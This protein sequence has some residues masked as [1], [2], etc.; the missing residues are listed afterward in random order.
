MMIR[1]IRVEDACS[2][3]SD[4]RANA[5]NVPRIPE[6]HEGSKQ[7]GG[8]AGSRRRSRPVS[9][10]RPSMLCCVPRR[11]RSASLS[12]GVLIRSVCLTA[13]AQYT[14]ACTP[15]PATPRA[16]CLLATGAL[17]S[18]VGRP[19][20]GR[21]WLGRCCPLVA[22][23]GRCWVGVDAGIPETSW[24]PALPL[25]PQHRVTLE[26]PSPSLGLSSPPEAGEVGAWGG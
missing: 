26:G 1:V 19:Q 10:G 4:Q 23:A 12:L 8:K 16:P 2:T 22:A 20:R 18:G 13:L 3:S 21:P 11:L 7:P 17:Q 25:T 14:S 24:S 6:N 9:S 5:Q 15:G